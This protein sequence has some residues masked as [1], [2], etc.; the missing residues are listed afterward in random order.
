MNSHEDRE[1][2][3]GLFAISTA[4]HVFA[5]VGLGLAPSTEEMLLKRAV[6]FQIVEPEKP[7]KVDEDTQNPE[8]PAESEPPPS[9]EPKPKARQR[10]QP[11]APD[12][13]EQQQTPH[14][15]QPTDV[16]PIEFP[17]V[18]LTSDNPAARWATV[19]G[20]GK[21]ITAPVVVSRRTADRE[22][23]GSQQASATGGRPRARGQKPR[24]RPPQ[25]P[26]NMDETLLQNYPKQ[27]RTQGIEGHALL[28]LRILADGRVADVRIVR[29]T[30]AGFG[31]ACERTV[32]SGRWRPRLDDAGRP[33]AVNITYTCRFEVGY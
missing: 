27:A 17:G 15:Q 19:V 31:R 26:E 20:S 9:P 18:T 29:E 13:S 24:S 8:P 32:R 11:R 2:V 23:R 12:P 30:Y 5:F 22:G 14:E 3:F 21:R 10:V 28:K 1:R 6:E 4:A 33:V 7:A 16:A 25:Q